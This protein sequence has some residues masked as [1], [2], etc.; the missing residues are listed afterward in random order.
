MKKLPLIAL[1]LGLIG[2]I[3]FGSTW[4]SQRASQGSALATAPPVSTTIDSG[5]KAAGPVVTG[6]IGAG[7][8]EPLLAH[9]AGRVK[10]VSFA[11]GDYVHQGDVLAKLFNFS[12]IIAPRSGF[13]G[14]RQIAEGQ[15]VTAKTVVTSISK[16]NHL[17]VI[18]DSLPDGQASYQPGDSVR[19][20]VAS[21]PERVVTGVVS[22]ASPTGAAASV[23]ITLGPGAPFRIG[24]RACTQ[25][26]DASLMAAE[27]PAH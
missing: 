16:S 13:L 14:K 3:A 19:V 6:L 24:E 7:G 17:V 2:L 11:D 15:Y 8:E 10:R 21:R 22:P 26:P 23:E 18:L 9:V 5:R 27:L 20:W 1:S 25:R 12:F 4:W